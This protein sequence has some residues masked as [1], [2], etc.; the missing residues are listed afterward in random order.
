LIEPQDGRE[1]RVVVQLLGVDTQ[2]REEISWLISRVAFLAPVAVGD[3]GGD[4]PE[5]KVPAALSFL[6]SGLQR[7]EFRQREGPKLLVIT[8]SEVKAPDRP[9]R[10]PV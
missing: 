8:E 5:P 3:D 7:I 1:E 10:D 2:P 6:P 9:D 4:H